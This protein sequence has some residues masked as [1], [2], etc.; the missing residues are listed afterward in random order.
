MKRMNQ[1]LILALIC[2]FAAA[3][4]AHAAEGTAM[5]R[6]ILR[7][8]APESGKAG[9]TVTLDES[10]A[11]SIPSD[12]EPVPPEEEKNVCFL[13]RGT[14]GEGRSLR[15][16]G[17]KP[18]NGA[19]GLTFSSYT[20]MKNQ[21]DASRMSH[22]MARLS[23]VELIFACTDDAVMGMLLTKKGDLCLP[24]FGSEKD[25]L[26]EI[27]QSEKLMNDLAFIWHSMHPLDGS[28]WQCFDEEIWK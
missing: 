24:L 9:S 18:G 27:R 6:E 17:L 5:I 1:Y 4:S 16:G 21:L 22:V 12:W 14:D 25:S 3:S 15:F 7:H 28:A 10:L 26:Y 20:D 11:F 8:P 13:F 2:L 23:G 19:F